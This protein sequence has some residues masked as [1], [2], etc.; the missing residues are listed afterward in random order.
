MSSRSNPAPSTGAGSSTASPVAKRIQ[1]LIRLHP[2]TVERVKYWSRKHN[3]T[4]NEYLVEAIEE[5]IAR[6]NGDYDL[7]TL[8]LLRL[9]QLVD[10]TKALSTNVASL[11]GVLVN[12]LDSLLQLAR[13]DSYL[14]D[15]EDGELSPADVASA[16]AGD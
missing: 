13:G 15:E 5:K 7:P 2:D 16:V 3:L 1:K 12:G 4:E 10:E 8:E 14:F 9:N 11:E 6:E